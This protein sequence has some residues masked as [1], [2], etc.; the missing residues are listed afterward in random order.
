MGS[1][2]LTAF[3]WFRVM[4]H[5][6]RLG[7]WGATE[8]M[9]NVLVGC[10]WIVIISLGNTPSKWQGTLLSFSLSLS[11][12]LSPSLSLSLFSL[13]LS[14]CD[15]CAY[16]SIPLALFTTLWWLGIVLYLT[17]SFLPCLW[18]IIKRW[19]PRFHVEC[20]PLQAD[21]AEERHG[22]F[23][24]IVLGECFVGAAESHDFSGWDLVKHYTNSFL[25]VFIIFLLMMTFFGTCLSYPLLQKGN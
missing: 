14:L 1:R 16:V 6:P 15:V 20:P 4:M 3:I 22:L 11:L 18:D 13:S 10:V 7:V 17:L 24:V 5:I 25:L 12:F 2:F 23:V 8:V 19:R 9:F 21:L